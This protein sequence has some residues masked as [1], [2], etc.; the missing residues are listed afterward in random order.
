MIKLTESGT[1][2]GKGCVKYIEPE[3][4]LS[5]TDWSRLNSVP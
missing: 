4:V 2:Q 3:Y 1:N 5:E